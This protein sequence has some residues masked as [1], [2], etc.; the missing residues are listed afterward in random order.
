MLRLV[1]ALL[2]CAAVAIVTSPAAAAPPWR[3][4]PAASASG[5]GAPPAAPLVREMAPAWRRTHSPRTVPA[6]S[7]L[8][9]VVPDLQGPDLVRDIPLLTCAL[10]R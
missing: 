6:R 4:T 7:V 10:L 8:S 5:P 9:R 1:W 2:A 3:E